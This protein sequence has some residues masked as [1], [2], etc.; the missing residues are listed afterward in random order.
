MRK[1]IKTDS[2]MTQ[3][4]EIVNKDIKT[5]DIAAFHVFKKLEE[6]LNILRKDVKDTAKTQIELLDEN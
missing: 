6:I 3:M 5:V 4:L 2:E 1:L